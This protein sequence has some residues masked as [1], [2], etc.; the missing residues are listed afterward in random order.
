[1][2]IALG[3]VANPIAA[4]A[5]GA[6]CTLVPARARRP[7]RPQ[8]LDRRQSLA[9]RARSPWTMAQRARW[10]PGVPCSPPASPPLTAAS[11]AVTRWMFCP[12]TA[13]GWRAACPLTRPGICAASPGIN[14]TRSRR[15]SAGAAGTKRFT[16]T[17]WWSYRK[18]REMPASERAGNLASGSVSSRFIQALTTSQFVVLAPVKLPEPHLQHLPLAS[19]ALSAALVQFGRLQLAH[20]RMVGHPL[21]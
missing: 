9:A 3:S 10:R 6:R 5:E 15:F 18:R 14:Q 21:S 19:N 4:V 11:S 1:M 16:G 7:L 8:T 17:T 20:F 2:A 13:R 12:W